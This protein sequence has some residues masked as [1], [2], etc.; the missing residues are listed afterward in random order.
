MK[1]LILNS[2]MGFRMG[3]L[4]SEQPKCMTEV[5][6]RET[7]LSR[8]LRLIEEAGIKDVVITTGYYDEV[9]M[10][11]CNSLGFSLN[12][13][14]VKNDRYQET[15]YIY[16]IYTAR[17]Y[18]DDDLLF[19][20]GDLVFEERVLDQILNQKQSVMV[21]SSTVDLPDKDFKA[22]IKKD[23]DGQKYI[24]K[25]GIE[26]FNE[27][28]SAQALYKLNRDEWGKWLGKIVEFCERGDVA[29]YA[30]NAF[31]VV[32]EEC[33]IRPYDVKDM[34]C[35]EIDNSDD[36]AVV[37]AKLKEV[38][39]RIVYMCFASDVLHTAH[40]ELINKAKKY[41]R[42]VVGVM[43]DEAIETYKKPSKIPF[44]ERKALITNI[45][46]VHEVVVQTSLSY[47]DILK[48]LKPAFVFHG[49]DW[50]EGVQKPIRDEVVELLNIW[51]GILIEYPYNY[52]PKYEMIEDL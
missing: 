32:S 31:N 51:G 47:K 30:E 13:N 22:V 37:T 14:F 35:A 4:T 26:F 9:L 40:L 25:V 39:E 17:E 1:A 28:F 41:G 8:Q 23:N 7:I 18:L 2:G 24:D 52:N 11:Y 34:L 16:S 3:V 48:E 27:A 44:D 36:L 20:H 5:S 19:M 49:D 29:C 10:R 46:G 12:I 43:T 45:A 6:G 42:L 33:H 15:N 21:V 50:R 38:E